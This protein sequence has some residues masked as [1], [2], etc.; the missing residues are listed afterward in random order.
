MGDCLRAWLAFAHLG[1]VTPTTPGCWVFALERV[2][3]VPALAQCPVK[4]MDIIQ[5]WRESGFASADDVIPFVMSRC[6]VTRDALRDWDCHPVVGNVCS[7]LCTMV[8]VVPVASRYFSGR[9]DACFAVLKEWLQGGWAR[10]EPHS[11][12][13]SQLTG[14]QRVPLHKVLELETATGVQLP[15]DLRRVLLEVGDVG[16]ALFGQSIM[17]V[18][19]A[20]VRLATR[21]WLYDGPQTTV[22]EEDLEDGNLP[23]SFTLGYG[24]GYDTASVVV[25]LNGYNR[26]RVW[27]A[28]VE[29]G[30]DAGPLVPLQ[31]S[32]YWTSLRPMYGRASEVFLTMCRA[33]QL[34]M[35]ALS[36]VSEVEG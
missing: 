34:P 29:D 32:R 20:W 15:V 19:P 16:L 9:R 6:H 31:G 14:V 7:R 22:K 24:C 5:S 26:G 23:G 21:P 27:V 8:E 12:R 2:P 30:D 35:S 3:F 18:H 17:N 10:V 11:A 28:H 33:A 25:Q 36:L 4:A 1:C 13:L